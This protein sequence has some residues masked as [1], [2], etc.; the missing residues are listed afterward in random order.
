MVRAAMDYDAMAMDAEDVGPRVTV[1]EVMTP[2][3]D[4][5]FS[6]KDFRV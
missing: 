2:D 6:R 3:L 4:F 5:F 1:R